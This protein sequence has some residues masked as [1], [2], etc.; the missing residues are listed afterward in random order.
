M[1]TDDTDDRKDCIDI[2]AY[3]LAAIYWVIGHWWQLLITIAIAV[4]L[5][6]L[7]PWWK[8]GVMALAMLAVY[9]TAKKRQG[10][11]K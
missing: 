8:V 6:F 1:P 5:S 9:I 2:I 7:L 11:K 4:L 10:G 3:I